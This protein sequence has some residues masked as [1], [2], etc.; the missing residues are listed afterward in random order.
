MSL[1]FMVGPPWTMLQS[2]FV[3][4]GDCIAR[5][6]SSRT[7]GT[8]PRRDAKTRSPLLLADNLSSLDLRANRL[9]PERR[10]PAPCHMVM[11]CRRS[12]ST[13]A[14]GGGW[15]TAASWP[16]AETSAWGV[17]E[18]GASAWSMRK[19]LDSSRA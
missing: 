10:P 11:R 15:N 3:A 13:Q 14:S 2:R 4:K 17:G 18:W 1:V 6:T 5:A 9:R 12:V 7:P 8:A 16:L 19:E